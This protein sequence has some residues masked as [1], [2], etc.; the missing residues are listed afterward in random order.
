ML[1][2]KEIIELFE[3]YLNEN[4]LFFDFKDWAEEKGY[5]LEELGISE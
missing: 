3:D 4:G 5:T 2:T 1:D